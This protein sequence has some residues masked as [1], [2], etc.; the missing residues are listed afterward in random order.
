M[1]LIKLLLWMMMCSFSISCRAQHTL[2]EVSSIKGVTSV[3]VGPA[4]LK[5]ADSSMNLDADKSA[6]DTSK[7]LKDLTSIEIITCEDK[8]V[9]EK[10]KKECDRVLSNFPFEVITEVTNDEQNVDISGVFEEDGKTISMLLI[11][12]TEPDEATY[13]L[14]KGKIDIETLNSALIQD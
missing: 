14:M 13:V 5:L 8:N 6:I 9:A 7:L 2:S 1:R 10:A 4:M 11:S 12:V 3:F